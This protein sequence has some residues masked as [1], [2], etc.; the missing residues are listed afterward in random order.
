MADR[1]RWRKS[2]YSGGGDGNACVEVASGRTRVGIRDS[3]APGRAALTIP[4]AGFTVFLEAL[5][6]PTSMP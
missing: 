4:A 6:S 2:S 5:K 1:V 3:K